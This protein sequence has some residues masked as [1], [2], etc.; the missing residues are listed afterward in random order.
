M[1]FLSISEAADVLNVSPRQIRR[2]GL[3]STRTAGANARIFDAAD[4]TVLRVYVEL[5]KRFSRW[6][7]AQWK[8]RAA[9]LYLEPYVRVAVL[10][11]SEMAIV[12]DDVRGVCEVRRVSAV[13]PRDVVLRVSA[14]H[15]ESV[16][17]V[18]ERRERQ[19]EVW[20]G[21]GYTRR[22]TLARASA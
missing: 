4:L 6:D 17:A 9:A 12:V 18:E 1:R 11:S 3:G 22:P 8:A 16:R 7:L 13:G 15:A 14:L 5:A 10:G 21:Y 19:P 2:L 20:A